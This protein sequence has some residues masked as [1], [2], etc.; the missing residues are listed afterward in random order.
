MHAKGSRLLGFTQEL[1][2]DTADVGAELEAVMLR[3][4]ADKYTLHHRDGHGD[5]P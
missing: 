5:H 3:E 4:L 2:D 1:F